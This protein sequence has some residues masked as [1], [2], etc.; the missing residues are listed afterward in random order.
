MVTIA[1][2]IHEK[3]PGTKAWKPK[4]F[5]MFEPPDIDL[6]KLQLSPPTRLIEAAAN[7][8]DDHIQPEIDE[9]YEYFKDQISK[10]FDD[11]HEVY[12]DWSAAVRSMY[13]LQALGDILIPADYNP[14]RYTGENGS[15]MDQL[16]NEQ[17]KY[18]DMSE[19]RIYSGSTLRSS[20]CY[21]ALVA[22]VLRTLLPLSEPPTNCSFNLREGVP[23]RGYNDNQ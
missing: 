19:V 6:V 18:Y 12:R 3:I 4:P 5:L 22:L 2:I 9:T 13:S 14:P 1:N 21:H 23:S 17:K 7:A 10:S 15:T 20:I 11:V 8:Y 16:E